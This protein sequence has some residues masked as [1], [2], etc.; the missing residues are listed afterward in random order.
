VPVEH[1]PV[2]EIGVAGAD[3]L[4][5]RPGTAHPVLVFLGRRI[6]VALFTLV[7][8]SVLIF[9][10]TQVLPGDAANAILGRNA[11]PASLAALRHQLHL[12]TPLYEQYG[13]WIAGL[14]R[15]DLGRSGASQL[16]IAGL[17]G[18]PARNSVILAGCAALLLIPLALLLGIS[19]AARSG[20]SADHV[21]SSGSLALTALPEF[22]TGTILI[23]IFA[24]GLGALPA[25][26]FLT[27]SQSPLQHPAILVLPVV[28]LL[29]AS[30]AQTLR[31]VRAGM[32]E[33]L[34]SEYVQMARLNGYRERDVVLRFALRN[35]LAPTVQVF[36]LNIQ[37]LVGGIVVTEYVFGYP[38]LGQALVNAVASRDIPLVQTVALLIAA[39]YLLL[40]IVADLL[41]VL[42]IPKLRTAL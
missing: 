20:R 22:V 34:N 40:N 25:V 24:L 42:L 2:T 21:I 5:T 37:W 16:P 8:I 12:D 29:S 27:A 35:A 28:T 3:L 18:G 10:G 23:L 1:D 30:L 26:S 9:V 19:A 6:L 15:G 31:M 4:E 11:T 13:R 36:A 33:A 41:V 32:V 7:V 39:V 38:G 14:V 17:I